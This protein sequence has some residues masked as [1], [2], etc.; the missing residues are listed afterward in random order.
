MTSELHDHG[1]RAAVGT[2]QFSFIHNVDYYTP[3]A[4]RFKK[5]VSNFSAYFS[6][7]F[8]LQIP[9]SAAIING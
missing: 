5:K 1:L 3:S 8:L 2:K 9:A 7:T 4:P 6:P